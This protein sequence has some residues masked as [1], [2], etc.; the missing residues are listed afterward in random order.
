MQSSCVVSISLDNWQET[1]WRN[2]Y[3]HGHWTI[4]F[5][6]K[7]QG[8]KLVYMLSIDAFFPLILSI[9]C[10][11]LPRTWNLQI[12]VLRVFLSFY[13]Y[14]APGF[15]T[16]ESSVSHAF[17]HPDMVAHTSPPAVPGKPALS[18][19]QRLLGKPRS[20]KAWVTQT[21]MYSLVIPPVDSTATLTKAHAVSSKW[22]RICL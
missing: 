21:H 10:W 20:E 17:S 18:A 13:C 14:N 1:I 4:L 16:T 7:W 19:Q 3:V 8:E 12:G 6:D 22:S 2:C 15:S 9:Q 11:L 5:R